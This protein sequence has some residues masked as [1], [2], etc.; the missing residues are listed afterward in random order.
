MILIL[1]SCSKGYDD[2]FK[3]EVFLKNQLCENIARGMRYKVLGLMPK[4]EFNV[5][6][7]SQNVEINV[8]DDHSVA[9]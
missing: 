3:L 4:G 5:Y 8:V 1:T 2:Y 6:R 7:P 9:L